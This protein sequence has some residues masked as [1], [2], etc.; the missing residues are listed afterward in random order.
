MSDDVTT[1][2]RAAPREERGGFTPI[3]AVEVSTPEWLRR[4]SWPAVLIG[5]FGVLPVIGV[6]LEIAGAPRLH[7]L[8]YWTVLTQLTNDDGTLIP[9]ALVKYHNE[10]PMFVPA[11]I[12]WLDAKFLGG[13]N[14]A[15]GALTAVFA[16]GLAVV[17]NRMLP[18]TLAR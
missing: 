15:L 11:L 2:R 4:V 17:L 6:A 14:H 10:H 18:R 5:V 13:N 16:L 12:F 9:R 7:F 3:S 8:D 1:D